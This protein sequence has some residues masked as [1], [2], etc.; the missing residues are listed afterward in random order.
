[1]DRYAPQIAVV[2]IG[3][4]G[5]LK[6]ASAKVCI[7]GAGGLGTPVATML[8][9]VG[10]GSIIIVDG[11]RVAPSNLHR[12]FQF[13]PADIGKPK[14]EVLAAQLRLQN[15]AIEVVAIAEHLTD[16]NAEQLISSAEVVADC[17]DQLE[18]RLLVDRMCASLSKPLVFAAIGGWEGY[19]TILHHHQRFALDQAFDLAGFYADAVLNCAQTGIVPTTCGVVGN[20][21]ANE[22]LKILLGL[23]NVLDGQL[24]C[25]D[26]KKVVFRKFVLSK[27]A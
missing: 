21:Q 9:A 8:A 17:T 14:A 24:L 23:D 4:E 12:Q 22:V 7:I 26:L 5:Q 18:S 2:E 3:A 20:L 25:V 1:M 11:D 6:L 13:T 27:P 19:L 15:P 10:V 16:E